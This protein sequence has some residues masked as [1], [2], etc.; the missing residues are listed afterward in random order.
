M[1]ISRSKFILLCT[2]SKLCFPCCMYSDV[3]SSHI[4]TLSLAYKS[5]CLFLFL[6]LFLSVCVVMYH[7]GNDV[8]VW[9]CPLCADMLQRN[10]TR[11][12]WGSQPVCG[13]ASWPLLSAL[14]DRQRNP[15][16][17]PFGLQC[18]PDAA[19][20]TLSNNPFIKCSWLTW[21]EELQFPN[22][23]C[24]KA[25]LRKSPLIFHSELWA[26]APFF[27]FQLLRNDCV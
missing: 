26:P 11:Q 12:V 3:V 8:S 27:F 20:Q 1:Q 19:Q 13:P 18:L 22:S 21:Q 4:P 9:A 5:T 23:C 15:L 25:M 10:A 17:R 7:F 16:I 14:S 24:T 6:P 2:D